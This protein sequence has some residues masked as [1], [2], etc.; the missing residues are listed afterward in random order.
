[1]LVGLNPVLIGLSCLGLVAIVLSALRPHLTLPLFFVWV[2]FADL[3]KRLLWLPSGV[4]PSWTEYQIALLLPDLILVAGAA[5]A[6]Y[7]LLI[8]RSI[9]YKPIWL[10]LPVGLF[11][12]WSFLN[13]FNPAS[14]VYV[15]LVGFKSSAFYIA[16]YALLRL[17]WALR[18]LLRLRAI[19]VVTA[20]IAA[21][22]AIVQ[23]VAGFRPFELAW[24]SSG[25]SELGGQSGD[26]GLTIA[27][28]GIERPFSTFASHEQLAWYV[29]GALLLLASFPR[30]TWYQWIALAILA[31]A[32]PRILSR[33][34]WAFTFAGVGAAI[35]LALAYRVKRALVPLVAI[36]LIFGAGYAGWS[37][38]QQVTG[39]ETEDA[40]A[41]EQ[42]ATML[43]TFE[44]RVYTFEA[45][46]GDSNWRRPLGNGTGSMWYAWRLGQPGATNPESEEVR[47]LGP[48]GLPEGKRVLS[49]VGTVDIIYELGLLGLGLFVWLLAAAVI[50]GWRV[51]RSAGSASARLWIIVAI[52]LALGVVAANSTITTVLAF[53]P[54]ASLF[55]LAI[56]I[57]GVFA[58]DTEK[59][60][61]PGAAPVSVSS[62]SL[63]GT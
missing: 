43:G 58:V 39:A 40:N 49:H 22:Y 42:R 19:I 36:P 53:R 18:T 17:Y 62:G 25:L 4:T 61:A 15:G 8:A 21:A 37:G 20:A 35:A 46:I 38:L 57:V 34:A 23:I 24:L 13:I 30:R 33:S 3:G 11:L 50:S 55:W 16:I 26:L 59:A 29:G 45:L 47:E 28:F 1:M 6:A 54:I 31:L 9:R 7:D 63:A 52:A 5:R 27:M 48:T 60:T 41:F 32:L 12:A 51:L 2:P 14:T 10:D 56:A 44:W